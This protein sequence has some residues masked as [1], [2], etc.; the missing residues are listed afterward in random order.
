[1]LEIFERLF[2]KNEDEL[3]AADPEVKKY[4]PAILSNIS[5]L[6]SFIPSDNNILSIE[7]SYIDS[8]L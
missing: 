5:T 7:V 2:E 3:T 6:S 4:H 1:M 8:N